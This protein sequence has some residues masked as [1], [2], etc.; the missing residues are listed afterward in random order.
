MAACSLTK[1]IMGF[2]LRRKIPEIHPYTL[3]KWVKSSWFSDM[4]HVN[5]R[6]GKVYF[7]IDEFTNCHDVP[8]GI[9]AVSLLHFFF[10]LLEIIPHQESGRAYISKGLLRKAQ[11]I[12][13]HNV[14]LFGKL[15]SEEVPLVGIEPSCI[16][17]F[18]DEYPE[19]VSSALCED[20]R[21]LAPNTLTIEE[22]IVREWKQGRISSS[23]FTEK[24]ANIAF[25]GHCHQKALTTTQA[26][27]DMLSI[28]VN[29]TVNELKTGCC[30]MAGSFG[31]EKKN[32]ILS[33]QI[34]ELALFPQVRETSAETI[35][36]APGTSCRE[37]IGHGT[38]RQAKHPVE[39]L[40]E[41]LKMHRNLKGKSYHT[42]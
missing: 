17:T 11:K 26:T 40:Y 33:M 3:R 25:H 9:K 41:A 39:V 7:F 13:D 2:D 10:F 5:P 8:I 28:P 12:A 18:R 36:A 1:Y 14:A 15:I 23:S 20:A 34:G 19:L 22:F 31:Y 29:Y 21:Q 24:P 38:G 16:L 27:R 42:D 6:M 35:I 32:Y 30:G 4:Q 37:H